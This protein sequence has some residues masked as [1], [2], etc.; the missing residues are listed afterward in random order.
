MNKP[1]GEPQKNIE[2]EPQ[3]KPEEI[4]EIEK[5][6]HMRG[7]A[8]RVGENMAD[9][10]KERAESWKKIQD[11]KEN[12][13]RELS[14]ARDLLGIEPEQDGDAEVNNNKPALDRLEQ[15]FDKRM[16]NS[17]NP[18][19]LK[20]LFEKTKTDN[21]R[22]KIAGMLMSEMNLEKRQA[23]YPPNP[24]Y[25]KAYDQATQDDA[26]PYKIQ[27]DW[28]YRGNFPSKENP[29]ATRGSLNIT[30]EEGTI[31]ELDALIKNGVIDANYKFGEPGA[32]TDASDRHDAVT[33]YFLSQPA[34]EAISAMSAIGQKYYRG[35]NLIGRKVSDGFY[36]SEIGSIS[37][38]NAKEL[39]NKLAQWDADLSKA[40][41]G[42]LTSNTTGKERVAMS[43]AQYYS[44]KDALNLFG[45]DIKYDDKKGFEIL[46][47]KNK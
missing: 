11:Q 26:L 10:N 18:G 2:Q 22:T 46:E 47:V 38:G 16:A 43:E 33:I 1:E 32:K 19:A 3:I 8:V 12:D 40:M 13:R 31:A 14:S 21:D 25:Q 4:E 9:Y 24:N 41:A 20:D 6:M 39:I 17:K 36:M 29:T 45:L 28:V 44:A 15:F 7:R 37:D 23:D 42:F 35:D 30:L 34:P 5:E 27:S